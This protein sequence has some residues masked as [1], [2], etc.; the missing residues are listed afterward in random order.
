MGAGANARVQSKV[1]APASARRVVLSVHRWVGL[2]MALFLLIEGITGAMLAF[3]GPLTRYFDPA[4]FSTAPTP[5]ARRLDLATL[6]E[7][8]EQR[9]PRGE[10][11]W[12]LPMESDVA[13]LYL[14][15]KS[16]RSQAGTFAPTYLALD[17]WTGR[18]V[19]RM[20]GGLYSRSGLLANVMPFVYD[21]HK[22]L[23]L[24]STGV[25]L[26]AITA[27]LW[28]LD[29]LWAVYLTFPRG[30]TR[31]WSRWKPS[32]LIKWR[33]RWP[34]VNYDAHRASSLWLWLPLLLFAWSSVAL[35]D[36]LSVYD[37]TMRG[38]LGAPNYP[39]MAAL[40]GPTRPHA[41]P[42]LD[43]HQALARGEMLGEAIARRESFTLAEANS[44]WFDERSHQYSIRFRTSR[45]FPRD[46][47]LIF[48]FDGDTGVPG[49]V[50]ATTDG[51]AN[52]TATAWLVAFHMVGD[53]FDY[54]A[55]RAFVCL[56]GTLLAAISVTGVVIWLA[57]R[58]TR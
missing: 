52:A 17:P 27:L 35:L 12:F 58:R 39:S 22:T 43:W 40:S 48:Y 7:I 38:L 26:L 37:V 9:E 11:H 15:P 33:A 25:W 13:L 2:A 41:T 20:D 4:L 28:T 5:N 45:R 50:I 3:R 1:V 46:Q 55:Y 14:V 51:N 16:D 53:P 31:F 18:E 23:A 19:R 8:A 54:T 29:S 57:K 6:I 21:L 44:I 34:R 56:L 47:D 49:P 24:G 10:F 36:N 30:M 32:W 42:R